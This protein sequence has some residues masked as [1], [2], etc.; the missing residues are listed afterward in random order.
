[1]KGRMPK[2]DSGSGDDRPLEDASRTEESYDSSTPTM[3][4]G[5]GDHSSSLSSS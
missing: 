1:M 5:T 3:G 2:P 4:S